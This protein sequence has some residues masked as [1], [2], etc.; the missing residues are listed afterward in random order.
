MKSDGKILNGSRS[1]TEVL[2]DEFRGTGADNWFKL[3]HL[4]QE[5]EFL[6]KELW[7]SV[8]EYVARLHE[9]SIR[10]PVP[11]LPYPWEEIGPG[12]VGGRAFGHWDIIHQILDV[13]PA[14]PGHSWRQ[15]Q[16]NFANQREDGHLPG[17]I[18]F[19]DNPNPIMKG[20]YP[21]FSPTSGHP[22]VWP[23]AVSDYFDRYGDE[24]LLRDGLRVAE[25]QV[26]WFESNRQSEDGGFY[27]LDVLENRWES[28]VDEGIRFLTRPETP[29]AC[30]D[31]TSHTYLLYDSI[32]KWRSLLGLEP[33]SEVEKAEALKRLINTKLYC[34]KSG[35]FF[36]AWS[37]KAKE[38][39]Y[40]FEG[41]WPIVVGAATSDQAEGVVR[42]NLLNS[43]H[44]FTKH[45]MATIS[46]SDR[47]RFALR[48]WRGPAW[49]SMT[50][51][52]ARGCARYD[53]H[54][55]AADLLETA[56]DM[57]SAAFE[58]TGTI[59]EFYHPFGGNPIELE[60]K[61]QD[62]FNTPCMDYLGHNPLFAMARL[63]GHCRQ[64]TADSL[65]SAS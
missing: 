28:G 57:T 42:Q 59:W 64:A 1:R 7:R 35:F 27:Y 53:Y 32:R 36:D 12:Y 40:A 2:S 61:P 24:E 38:K 41:M 19:A 58:T 6:G 47:K 23:L 17:T 18:Y 8:L 22:P 4:R 33:G 34:E 39:P 25:K 30:V 5:A 21:Y 9:A 11:F 29:Q 43:G 10:P 15:L 3:P 26:K 13:L 48:C 54:Q 31:A 46:I 62:N 45:P 55:E 20:N 65:G 49:N 60:R 14:E 56:L 44:F 37:V 16:N 52:A 63:W 50:Y 51:W